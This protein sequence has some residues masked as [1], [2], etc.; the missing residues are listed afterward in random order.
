MA[1]WGSESSSQEN[2]WTIFRL[3]GLRLGT[4]DQE[5]SS[6]AYTTMLESWRLDIGYLILVSS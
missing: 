6:W 2:S 4:P 5:F 1:P 3:L